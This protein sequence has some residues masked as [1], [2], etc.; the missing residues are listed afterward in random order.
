MTAAERLEWAEQLL[1]TL[2]EAADECPYCHADEEEEEGVCATDCELAA[3]F[4]AK[5]R[6]S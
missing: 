5:E 6:K 2:Y 1:R 4:E 3:F